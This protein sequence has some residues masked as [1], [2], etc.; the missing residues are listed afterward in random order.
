MLFSYNNLIS[1]IK[2]ETEG[3]MGVHLPMISMHYIEFVNQ[4][5]LDPDDY[6]TFKHYIKNASYPEKKHLFEQLGFRVI[7]LTL[8]A[9][10][11]SHFA[12]DTANKANSIDDDFLANKRNVFLLD[13][14]V[15][16]DSLYFV[17]EYQDK[18]D[19]LADYTVD[20]EEIKREEERQEKIRA[21]FGKN[22]K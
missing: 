18:N 12:K 11:I 2:E 21:I 4:A 9:T 22:K 1:Q 14:S 6:P 19:P 7:Y 5:G 17:L 10:K 3:I 15:G 20:R 16:L 8:S 13:I